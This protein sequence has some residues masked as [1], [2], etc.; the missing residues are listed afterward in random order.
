MAHKDGFTGCMVADVHEIFSPEELGKIFEDMGNDDRRQEEDFKNDLSVP[1]NFLLNYHR[2]Y[3]NE[4]FPLKV[5]RVL[6]I[7]VSSAV[8][9]YKMRGSIEISAFH[10]GAFK[11]GLV[12]F[13]HVYYSA[14]M[15]DPADEDTEVWFLRCG[16]EEC[17]IEGKEKY[18]CSKCL[19]R[20]EKNVD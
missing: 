18:K 15:R 20:G 13:T 10:N 12:T 2:Y 9:S 19:D 16:K 5:H 3:D 1:Y 17:H 4:F 6:D 7:N 8:M 14:T 11:R